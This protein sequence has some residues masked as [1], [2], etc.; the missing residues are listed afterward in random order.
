ME[1]GTLIRTAR[2]SSGLSQM[3]LSQRSGVAQPTISSYERGVHEPTYAVLRHLVASAGL[4]LDIT[5]RRPEEPKDLPASETGLL[6]RDRRQDLLAAAE[7][8][9][10]RN[11][12]V[13]GS[14][15]RGDDRSRSDVDFLID[16]APNVGIVGLNLLK[17]EF[18]RIL[19]RNV[20]VVP[21]SGLKAAIRDEI[22]R[23]AIPLE[24]A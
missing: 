5:L 20:D 22:L 15:A 2:Q 17:E 16:L 21:R 7:R 3:A 9:G 14:V 18:E 10:A 4:R 23:E 12:H 19:D 1:A 6:L 8:H 24:P 11:V 13:F